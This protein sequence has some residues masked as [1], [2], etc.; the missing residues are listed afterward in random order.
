MFSKFGRSYKRGGEDEEGVSKLAR[1]L[2]RPTVCSDGDR[3]L[4]GIDGGVLRQECEESAWRARDDLCGYNMEKADKLRID[5]LREMVE[6]I[7][8]PF[9]AVEFLVAGK[10]LHLSLHEWCKSRNHS[11]SSSIN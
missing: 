1:V 8:T 3:V 6:R 4:E 10:K 9:Q 5:T 2:S 7:L 11:E